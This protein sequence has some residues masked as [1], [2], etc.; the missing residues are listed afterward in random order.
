[1]PDR[2]NGMNVAIG[3]VLLL[4]GVGMIV[5][6][7][8]RPGGHL[9]PLLDIWIIGQVYVM[10]SMVSLVFGVTLLLNSWPG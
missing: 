5:I 3:V 9:I 4:I 2:G 10:A 1:M 7:R 6:G 8:P